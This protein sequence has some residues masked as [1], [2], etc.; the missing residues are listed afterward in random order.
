MPLA[1]IR[2]DWLPVRRLCRGALMCVVGVATGAAAAEYPIEIAGQ[3]I[4]VKTTVNGSG[5]FTFILDTGATETVV[6]PPTA[7]RAGIA[8]GAEPG[9][10]GHGR[11]RVVAVGEVAVTNLPVLIV[12]PPQALSLRLDKG[13]NYGGILGYTFLSPQVTTIDYRQKWIAFAPAAAASAGNPRL[14]A[15]GGASEV[16]FV[17]R[18]HLIHVAAFV[19]G[20]GPLT[21]LLDTGSAEVV[22]LPKAQQAIGL[23]VSDPRSDG[24]RF[25]TLE[26]LRVG[27]AEVINVPAIVQRPPQEAAL[28]LTYD[29]IVGYPFLSHFRVVIDYHARLIT[30]LPQAEA[31]RP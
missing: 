7:R 11:A 18:D 5:P 29:G 23:A 28:G 21:F 26:R 2:L 16:P 30:L 4:L 1:Y 6:T 22:L 20:R 31:G 24:V 25:S 27:S 3:V 12:D 19:N 15:G 17:L 13:I 8:G 9:L 14:A 10:V